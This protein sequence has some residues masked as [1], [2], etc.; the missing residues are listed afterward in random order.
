[1][2]AG[3]LQSIYRL[4]EHFS[5]IIKDSQHSLQ[6][7]IGSFYTK[8]H[9]SVHLHLLYCLVLKTTGFFSMMYMKISVLTF[10]SLSY[11]ICMLDFYLWLLQYTKLT[12]N[13]YTIVRNIF[14]L[15][16]HHLQNG[17]LEIGYYCHYCILGVS[18]F[19]IQTRW[20]IISR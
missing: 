2:P 12:L 8:P 13:Q 5:L 1:M 20:R 10:C 16:K 17:L 19:K 9:A 18:V 6:L 14:F 4:K 7:K 3:M 11:H 15:N